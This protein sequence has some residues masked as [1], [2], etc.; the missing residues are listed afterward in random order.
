MCAQ[1]GYNQYEVS[2]FT[3][4]DTLKSKHN[5]GY[6]NGMDYLGVGPGAHGRFKSKDSSIIKTFRILE[7]KKWIHEIQSIGHGTK[8]IQVISSYTLLKEIV[9]LGLRTLEGISLD[10]VKHI[11]DIDKVNELVEQGFL[12]YGNNGSKLMPTSMGLQ[13]MDSILPVIIK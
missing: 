1:S 10:S 12:N 11:L 8:K 5:L 7:P 2:T 3:I 13:L 6:W 9:V 4:A